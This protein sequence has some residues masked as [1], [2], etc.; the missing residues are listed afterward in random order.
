M[1]F[2]SYE[3][4]FFFPIVSLLY[5]VIPRNNWRIIFLLLA[6]Y[7]FYMC[8]NPV[9]IVLIFASTVIDFFIGKSIENA[10]S[11]VQKRKFLSVSLIANLGILLY[12]K[13]YNFL[14]TN[15]QIGLSL[16]GLD[17]EVP[18]HSFLLPVGISFYTFQTLSYT[19]D[20]YYGKLKAENNFL[21]FALYVSFFPQLVA[22]P[23]ERSVNL[24]PQFLSKKEF[25]YHRVSDG[26]KLILWGLFK[27]IVAADSFALYVD[28]VYSDPDSFGG[29]AI[30]MASIF[31]V[32]QIYC[33]FSGY[34]DIAIGSARVLGFDLM[35]NFKGPLLSRNISELW[36]RWHISLSSW[37]RDYL[38]NP[39]AFKWRALG[40]TGLILSLVITFALVGVWHGANWT[41]ILFGFLHGM[42][43]SYEAL[44]RKFRK[45]LSKKIPKV[46]Y[47][48][49]SV[50][51]TFIFWTFTLLLF[52]SSSVTEAGLL[53]GKI[54][55]ISNDTMSIDIYPAIYDKV[56]MYLSFCILIFIILTHFIE[57]HKNAIEFINPLPKLTRWSI[58]LVLVLAIINFGEYGEYRQ[59]IYFQF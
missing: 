38:Y 34:S 18:Q 35:E 30:L 54:F 48:T 23:I 9:Y 21:R 4:L 2:N 58:Y 7:F 28:K 11:K 29:G 46:L 17:L 22:G 25:D 10:D 57:Y 6:S 27:K 37:I 33:D 49:L 40:D 43:M 13:Y 15:I 14:A 1:L 59:F 41:F 12:F 5:F 44:S 47:A 50:C 51:I 16:A 31:F 53:I 24:L 32:F 8:W 36:R 39:L 56:Q 42:A 45:R 20:I 3:Y 55:A 19:L 26:L 52:R